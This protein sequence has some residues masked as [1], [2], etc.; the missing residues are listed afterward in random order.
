MLLN[1]SI[2]WKSINSNN[3]MTTSIQLAIIL[4]FTALWE[5]KIVQMVVIW[6]FLSE[7]SINGNMYIFISHYSSS[8]YTEFQMTAICPIFISQSAVKA[9][10]IANC[11]DFVI[12][13]VEL[14]DFHLI[15]GFNSKNIFNPYVSFFLGRPLFLVKKM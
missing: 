15:E 12:K 7:L 11:I 13:L 8:D 2:R 5:M 10:I 4:A 9:W 1:P 14:I 6:N 3:Y